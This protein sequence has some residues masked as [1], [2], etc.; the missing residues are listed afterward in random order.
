LLYYS[1]GEMKRKTPMVGD[2]VRVRLERVDADRRH[3]DF[4]L[5]EKMDRE[6]GWRFGEKGKNG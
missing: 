5:I 2:E 3:I 4:G 1:L 6:R